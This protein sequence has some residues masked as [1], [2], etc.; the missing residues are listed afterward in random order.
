MWYCDCWLWFVFGLL[1]GIT[2]VLWFLSR[3]KGSKF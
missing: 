1:L 3:D 2:V